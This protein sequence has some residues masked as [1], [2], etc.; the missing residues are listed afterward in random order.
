MRGAVTSGPDDPPRVRPWRARL[1]EAL[2]WELKGLDAHVAAVLTLA[3]IILVVFKA[4][5]TPGAFHNLPTDLVE[6][7][8]K[9]VLSDL[10]WFGSSFV[11][12]GVVPAL[13]LSRLP[14][15][16]RADLGLGIG[17]WRFG[18][19][20]VAALYLIM[21]PVLFLVSR[22]E[23]FWR[24]YPLNDELGSQSLTW[25]RDGTPP[26]WLFWF[27]IYE[28]AYVL[29]F[30]GWEYFYRGFLTF[31]LHRVLGFNGVLIANVPFALMHAGK[32]FPEAMGSIV[33]GIALGLFA[34]RARS[35]WYCWLLHALIACSMD[36]LAIQR[37]FE[38]GT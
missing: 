12:L 21:L 33:A 26:D 3:A 15:V 34:L 31:G 20:G 32:P 38:A 28:A 16:T 29:Y 18:L 19:G 17:R 8:R 36:L 14:G 5:G 7:P 9:E 22:T 23:S 2:Q 4:F 13:A 6:H 37:R 25:L 10:W 11:M 24:Y 27:L 1:E 30:V 35:F